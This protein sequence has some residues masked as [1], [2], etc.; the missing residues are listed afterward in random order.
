MKRTLITIIA[1]LIAGTSAYAQ[2]HKYEARLGWFYGD[3]VDLIYRPGEDPEDGTIYG[4]RKTTGIFAAD[5][6]Y[7]VLKWLSVG[8]K[9]NYR[10]SWYEVTSFTDEGIQETSTERLQAFS[11]IPMVTGTTNPDSIFRYYIS[12]GFGAGIDMSSAQNDR[13]LAFQF[14]PVGISVGK[15]VSWYFE[16]GFGNAYGGFMTGVSYKF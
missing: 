4:P 14:I 10:N 15:K 1:L 16:F 3:L 12:L 9:L 7:N 5:F 13:Y 2:E 8:A 6:N 11:V